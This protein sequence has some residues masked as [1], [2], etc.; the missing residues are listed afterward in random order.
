M[1]H[2]WAMMKMNS[3]L[4]LYCMSKQSYNNKEAFIW[5][6]KENPKV[7]FGA[8]DKPSLVRG[9]PEEEISDVGMKFLFCSLNVSDDV[10]GCSCKLSG[11]PHSNLLKDL[12][13]LMAIIAVFWSLCQEVYRQ[14]A[15]L[16][17]KRHL[18]FSLEIPSQEKFW[19][20]K[21]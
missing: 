12:S 8:E 13:K 14:F 17:G 5:E 3:K 7:V 4:G 21:Y 19:E 1:S 6:Q 2:F 11:G 20:R 16:K 18:F 10:T 15:G 9:Q